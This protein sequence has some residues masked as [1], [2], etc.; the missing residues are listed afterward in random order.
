MDTEG[1]FYSRM[2]PN[3]RGPLKEKLRKLK[4]ALAWNERW[5]VTLRKNNKPYRLQTHRIVLETFIG[6]CPSNMETRH[7]D[8]NPQNNKIINLK[9][10]TKSENYSDRIRHGTS[11]IGEKNGSAKLNEKQVRVIKAFKQLKNRP[12]YQEIA[13]FFEVSRG[14]I[15]SIMVGRSWKHLKE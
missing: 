4:L 7:I 3:G 11:T 10:G 6:S 9:W 5:Y 8:G 13:E 2:S 1:N 12:T 14:C 15:K